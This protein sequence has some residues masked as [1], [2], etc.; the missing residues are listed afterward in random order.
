MS[1]AYFL[2]RPAACF[3]VVLELGLKAAVAQVPFVA[4]KVATEFETVPAGAVQ[5]ASDRE[6]T[7]VTGSA[8]G[9]L[10]AI[11]SAV[12]LVVI[13]RNCPAAERNLAVRTC[14]SR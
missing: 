4:W 10:A 5:A 12:A 8:A 6:R 2:A 1:L 13:A 7:A 14:C 9:S 3:P 11:D